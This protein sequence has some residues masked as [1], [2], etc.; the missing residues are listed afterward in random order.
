MM[1][2]IVVVLYTIKYLATDFIIILHF[3]IIL[4]EIMWKLFD[5]SS[6]FFFSGRAIWY[7]EYVAQGGR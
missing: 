4:I 5:A 3:H 1:M 7:F 6:R 2:M